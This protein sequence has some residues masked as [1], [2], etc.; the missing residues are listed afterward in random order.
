M[1]A[2]IG[3]IAAHEG[4]VRALTASPDAPT[5]I[6]SGGADAFLRVWDTSTPDL[7]R[8]SLSHNHTVTA[9]AIDH[10]HQY[11]VTGCMDCLIRIYNFSYQEV[12][13]LEGHSKGVI[14]LTFD[15]DYLISGSW[16]G[17]ARIW[18]LRTFDCI[19]MFEGHENGVNV[20][21]IGE[22][23]LITTS[24]GEAIDN[25]PCNFRIRIWDIHA[26]TLLR[27]P[28]ED[29]TASI[30]S[31]AKVDHFGFVTCSNDGTVKLYTYE[32]DLVDSM[33]HPLQV[34]HLCLT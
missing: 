4:A 30:R 33:S 24:T 14:S 11:I 34:R 9:V 23:K 28:I 10:A 26:G 15:G 12:I 16:D 21:S 22:G 2:L 8:M 17:C 6:L 19:R 31:I 1:Y 29:H 7:L 13:Q 32:G 20:L 5:M 27:A 18:D 3:Q 25:K